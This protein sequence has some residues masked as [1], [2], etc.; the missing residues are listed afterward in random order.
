[1][2][3]FPPF[4]HRRPFVPRLLCFTSP[5]HPSDYRFIFHRAHLS[6]FAFRFIL[7][8]FSGFRFQLAL[9]RRNITRLPLQ[10][11]CKDSQPLSVY[12]RDQ[13]AR[14]LRNK[15]LPA[16]EL[17]NT[18]IFCSLT[19]CQKRN[20]FFVNS[21]LRALKFEIEIIKCVGV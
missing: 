4:L 20:Q 17:V 21:K 8:L 15:L 9:Y 14:V 2:I 7:H 6:H 10:F 3:F 5:R 18:K 19:D 11:R 12:T 13:L 1:M 16:R